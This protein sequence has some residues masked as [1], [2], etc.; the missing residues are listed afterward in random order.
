MSMIS[1]AVMPMTQVTAISIPLSSDGGSALE[2]V[3]AAVAVA[4]RSPCLRLSLLPVAIL[5]NCTPFDLGVVTNQVDVVSNCSALNGKFRTV[6]ML[7]DQG[8][9][10]GL[11]THLAGHW[12]DAGASHAEHCSGLAASEEPPK[13]AGTGYGSA[14]GRAVRRAAPPAG[15]WDA[16][17]GRHASKPALRADCWH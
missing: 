1:H 2:V 8:V 3:V 5:H 17:E 9:T 11:V 10:S 14:N 13:A 7:V 15:W 6:N 4:P 12:W 16:C